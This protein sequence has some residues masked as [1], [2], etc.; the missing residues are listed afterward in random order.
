[1]RVE[2]EALV[3]VAEAKRQMSMGVGMADLL[4]WWLYYITVTIGMVR[5]VK[6]IMWVMMILLC[7]RVRRNATSSSDDLCG[8]EDKV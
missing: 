8:N 2:V 7:I 1:M 3:V 5:I 6:G 4:G